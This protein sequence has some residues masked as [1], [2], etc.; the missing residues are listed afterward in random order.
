MLLNVTRHVPGFRS[1]P[2]HTVTE[3][4]FAAVVGSGASISSSVPVCRIDRDRRRVLV[5]RARHLTLAVVQHV[6]A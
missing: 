4:P 1:Q 5:R 2:R 3:L 6:R